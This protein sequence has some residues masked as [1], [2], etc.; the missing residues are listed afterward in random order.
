M[1][2]LSV[3]LM[4][5]LMIALLAACSGSA[6][7]S[8]PASSNGTSGSDSSGKKDGEAAA[9]KPVDINLG[10]GFAIEENVWFMQYA[11][12]SIVP[13]RGKS[14]NLTMTRFRANT[15][16]LNAYQA[17]QLHGGTIGQASLMFAAAQGIPIKAVSVVAKETPG[18]GLNTPF[19]ALKSSGI[20]SMQDLKGKTIGVSDF[21][22]PTDF[23]ARSAIRSAGM[24][25]DKDVKWAVVPIPAMVESVKT[26]KIDVGMFTEPFRTIALETGEF[27]EVFNS[28]TGVPFDEEF[29]VLF[30]NPDFIKAN[31][32][33]VKDFLADYISAT[34]YFVG[35]TKE[36]KQI[37]LDN[38]YVQ[39][40][41]AI[42]LK[43]LDNNRALDGKMVK[44][45][46]EKSMDIMIKDGW[47]E[48]PV[49]LDALL[50]NSYLPQ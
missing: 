7:N 18:V 24:D 2:R 4:L 23:W 14:Y 35:N 34:K 20:S 37:L 9:S 26:G 45:N 32:Q 41:P 49:D 22:S 40:D 12:Q 11:D 8:N 46:W 29:F 33:A 17:G 13:N 19:M 30:M 47:L 44:E 28:K 31:E 39:S 43:A 48:K 27:T 21:K 15:D 25:P 16:R 3:V 42:Y 5:I 1:R 6:G 38:K 10:V 36:V 50:D